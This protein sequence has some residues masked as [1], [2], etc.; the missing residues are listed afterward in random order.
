MSKWISIEK[1]KKPK[2]N[3]VC[4]V[5]YN[6]YNTGCYVAGVA[7]Y[8][9]CCNE[10]FNRPHFAGEEADLTV[11]HWMPVPK[12]PYKNKIYVGVGKKFVFKK[13]AFKESEVAERRE[14]IE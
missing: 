4:F 7:R 14:G 1:R 10:M 3:Q 9:D 8:R 5:V 6:A 12:I 11:T 2:H 13:F